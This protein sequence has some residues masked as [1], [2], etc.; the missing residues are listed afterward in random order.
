MKDTENLMVKR[1]ESQANIDRD[2]QKINGE[3]ARLTK[4]RDDL[5]SKSG[6]ES[7]TQKLF[8]DR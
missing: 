4:D 1:K 3:I 6:G 8:E 7:L 2:K 5:V